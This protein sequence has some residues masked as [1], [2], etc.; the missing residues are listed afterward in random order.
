MFGFASPW[1][2]CPRGYIFQSDNRFFKLIV[3]TLYMLIW[4][5]PS[6]ERHEVTNNRM[7]IRIRVVISSRLTQFSVYNFSAITKH[8]IFLIRGTTVFLDN[9]MR[10]FGKAIWGFF[11]NKIFPQVSQWQ[12]LCFYIS[13]LWLFINHKA[14]KKLVSPRKR[15]RNWKNLIK[16][17][18]WFHW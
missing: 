16:F 10:C 13:K 15:M 5:F 1:N 3:H 17:T 6:V 9:I 8:T 2:I 18:C 7:R 11:L 14:D 4:C 12:D